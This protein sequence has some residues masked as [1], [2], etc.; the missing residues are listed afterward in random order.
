MSSELSLLS[1]QKNWRHHWMV[2]FREKKFIF[3]LFQKKYYFHFFFQSTQRGTKTWFIKIGTSLT[4]KFIISDLRDKKNFTFKQQKNYFLFTSVDTEAKNTLWEALH[5]FHVFTLLY[6][7]R[8]C[9]GGRK[10]DAHTVW[11][12]YWD[13][14]YDTHLCSNLAAIFSRTVS[15]YIYTQNQFNIKQSPPLNRKVTLTWGRLN[16][17]N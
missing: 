8:H 6:P 13:W 11:L 2:A 3:S 5:R 12:L 14:K 10:K 4:G 9:F 17:Q 15:T 7:R 16:I 1:T